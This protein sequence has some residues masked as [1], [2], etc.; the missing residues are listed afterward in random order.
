[1]LRSLTRKLRAAFEK[2]LVEGLKNDS[3]PFWKYCN[4]KVKNRVKVG[5]L[6]R[7]DETVTND[8]AEK[9]TE[10]SEYFSSVF[11]S[12]NFISMPHKHAVTAL[13]A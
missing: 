2:R 12:E 7:S 5:S 13:K 8:L 6:K 11:V 3:K 9:V 1:M 10:L 4:S